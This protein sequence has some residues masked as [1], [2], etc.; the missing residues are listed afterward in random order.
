[1][2]SILFSTAVLLAL[3]TTAAQAQVTPFKVDVAKST[4]KWTGKKVTGSHW[5]NVKISDGVINAEKGA[6]KNGNFTLDMNS[7]DVKDIPADKG[8]GKLAGHLKAD[9]FFATEKYPTAKLVLKSVTSDGGSA[10]CVAD[11]TIRDVTNEISFPAIIGIADNQ[12]TATADFKV[13]RTKWGIKYGSGNFFKELGDKAIYDDF[14]VS[15]NIVAA[16]D[17]PAAKPAAAAPAAT[18]KPKKKNTRKVQK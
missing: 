12:L 6:V 3:T 14:E 10:T 16:S 2:K 18:D 8:A 17:K 4:F 7:L 11:L 5:G 1:M 9:D 15:V 13:D